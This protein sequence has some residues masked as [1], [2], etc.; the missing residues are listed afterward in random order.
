MPDALPDFL[1]LGNI[2]LGLLGGTTFSLDRK[3]AI[4]GPRIHL[5]GALDVYLPTQ[6]D[7]DGECPFGRS[8]YCDP[9][10]AARSLR[11]FEQ[12]LFVEDVFSFR[13]RL[14][15]GF[16]YE[17]FTIHGELGLAPMFTLE[18]DSQTILL[19]DLALQA[20]VKL[21]HVEPFLGV[22]TS[23][24][25]SSA[26]RSLLNPR[27]DYTSSAQLN[28]GI[29]AHFDSL[30]PALLVAYNIDS[31]MIIFGLDIAAAARRTVE[32]SLDA[33]NRSN[34]RF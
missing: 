2:R 23:Q 17:L 10:R 21:P 15:A 13:T 29:R 16:S 33:G 6:T 27:P 20:S 32:S 8:A 4:D 18:S 14:H 31:E 22:T 1:V 5:G 24:D 7:P 9:Y 26:D 11:P 34:I 19:M 3:N 25:L 28:L 12:E 30:N